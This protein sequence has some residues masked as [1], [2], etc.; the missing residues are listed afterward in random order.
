LFDQLFRLHLRA[1]YE[2]AGLAVP[3]SLDV[4]ITEPSARRRPDRAPTA[5]VR[6]TID[7]RRTGFYE[8]QGAAHHALG[9]G[10]GSMHRAAGLATDLYLGFDAEQLYLRVDFASA[11]SPGG[12]YSLWLELIAPAPARIA[13]RGLAPGNPE[14]RWIGGPRDGQRVDGAHAAVQNLLEVAVPFASLGLG[15][16]DSVEMI[17]RLVQNGAPVETLPDDDLVRFRVPDPQFDAK[18]WTV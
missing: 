13:V 5:F 6:P 10:G 8:W 11:R 4:A 9:A 17:A 7:G 16:G 2:R 3:G 15:I 18:M 12:E 14:L 1:A